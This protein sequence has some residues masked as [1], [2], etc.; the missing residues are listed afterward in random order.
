MMLVLRSGAWDEL[1]HSRKQSTGDVSFLTGAAATRLT[2]TLSADGD[3][4]RR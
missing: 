1:S 2:G 4:R 3:V